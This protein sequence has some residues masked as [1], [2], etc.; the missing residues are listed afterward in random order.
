MTVTQ[1]GGGYT[2]VGA[3]VPVAMA[4]EL[5]RLAAQGER[6]MSAQIRLVLRDYLAEHNRTGSPR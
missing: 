3:H 4:T 1:A 5:A 6:S 2:V